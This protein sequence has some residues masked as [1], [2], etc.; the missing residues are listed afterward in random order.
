MFGA[1]MDIAKTSSVLFSIGHSN[2]PIDQFFDLLQR[3]GIRTVADVRSS[4]YSRYNPQFS[5]PEFERSLQQRGMDYVFLGAELGARRHEAECYLDG[6]VDYD[7]VPR[8]EAFQHGM[9]RLVDIASRSRVAMLCAEKDPLTCHRTILIAR[10]IT[11]FVGDV[12]HILPDGALEAQ[13]EAEQRLLVECNLHEQNLFLSRR[14]RLDEAYQ[15][16]AVHIAYEEP[17]PYA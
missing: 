14:Q 16:R 3:H 2:H 12:L 10:H 13:S 17:A 4:P 8:T 9:V 1:L 6:K 7:H 5:Q 15:K 11:E